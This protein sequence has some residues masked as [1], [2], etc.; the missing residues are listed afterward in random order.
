M[1][2]VFEGRG[3]GEGEGLR[4][5]VG[6]FDGAGIHLVVRAHAHPVIAAR[7]RFLVH[8]LHV[9]VDVEGGERLAAR[10]IQ[11]HGDGVDG[12][13]GA[14]FLCGVDL[15]GEGIIKVGMPRETKAVG[16]RCE[17]AD[18]YGLVVGKVFVV[19][20]EFDDV[21]LVCGVVGRNAA[22]ARR[23]VVRA[24]A[25]GIDGPVGVARPA[26]HQAA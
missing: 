3:K 1:A 17:V 23:V 11:P 7:K 2:A 20:P 25:K 13:R 21:P 6:H 14:D 26:K 19:H 22:H 18:G 16:G 9:D 12:A 4:V 5:R 10:M 24:V 8:F 15:L